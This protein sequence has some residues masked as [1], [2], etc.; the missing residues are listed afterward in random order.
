V[1]TNA[2][3]AEFIGTTALIFIG[4]GAAAVGVG[5]LVGVALAHGLVVVGMANTY[6]PI[7]GAHINPA[8]TFAIALSGKL[9]WKEAAG[10]WLVQL[11][12]GVFGAGLLFV[13]LGGASSGLGATLPAEGVSL[14]QAILLEATLTF[15]LVNAI[16]HTAV[17]QPASPQAGLAIGLTL[18][19][20]ILMGGPLT[21]ASLNPARSFG[22]ALFTGSLDLFWLYILGPALGAAL[23]ALVYRSISSP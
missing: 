4:V 14:T 3:L 16:L 5:G 7:S 15:L 23:A 17:R 1:K 19:A 21:G 11:A 8:V 12:G 6:G 10:Y 20:L 22:P 9:A 18:I 2:L 13:V